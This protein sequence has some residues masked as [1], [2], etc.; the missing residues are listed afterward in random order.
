MNYGGVIE[1]FI[2]IPRAAKQKS[3]CPRLTPLSPY[4]LTLYDPRTPVELD[5]VVAAE[6]GPKKGGGVLAQL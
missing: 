3:P 2:D 5:G 1:V 4:Y 6:D